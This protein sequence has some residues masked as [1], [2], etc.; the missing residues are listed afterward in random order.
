MT[1]SWAHWTNR[2]RGLRDIE[3]LGGEHIMRGSSGVVVSHL[4]PDHRCWVKQGMSAFCPHQAVNSVGAAAAN[5]PYHWLFHVALIQTT[6]YERGMVDLVSLDARHQHFDLTIS[7]GRGPCTILERGC[8]NSASI[9]VV[10]TV[11]LEENFTHGTSIWMLTR[12]PVW[13]G[14]VEQSH[15][16]SQRRHVMAALLARTNS[17]RS[18]AALVLLENPCSSCLR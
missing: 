9:I 2:D 10:E 16:S 5:L 4:G 14:C 8:F 1:I 7:P 11:D 12:G 13:K 18:T 17:I 15:L 6:R 3:A